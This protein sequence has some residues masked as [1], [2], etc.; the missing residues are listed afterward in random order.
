QA[1]A[2]G[3][4][5]LAVGLSPD[6]NIAASVDFSQPYVQHGRRLMYPE[7]RNLDQLSDLMPTSRIVATIAGDEGAFELAEAWADSVGVFNI[8]PFQTTIEDAADTILDDNNALVVFADSFLILPIVQNNPTELAIG[9]TWYDRQFLTLALPQND[10]DFRRLVNYTLQE[11]VR[12]Q[13]LTTITV[14]ILPEGE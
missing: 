2:N 1:V 10:I 9:P 5:D 6:W 7:G 14:P 8:R 3:Q 11:M 4:A 12:D 13:S